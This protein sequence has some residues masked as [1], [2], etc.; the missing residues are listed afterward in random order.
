M[1]RFR[2]V[3]VV[4]LAAA[5]TLAACSSSSKTSSSATTAAGGGVTVTT[6]GSGQSVDVTVSDTQGTN[7]PMTLVPATTS[8][9][10]GDVTF[11][12]KNT[13]TIEHEMLVIKTDTPFDKIPIVDAGDPPVSVAT[14][15]NKIDEGG[16]VADTGSTNLKP[17]ETRNLD[18]KN[19]APG[20]YVLVCNIADHYKLGMRA[21][22]T[23]TA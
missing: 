15:A 1:S 23:V 4:V 2:A 10:A 14:G 3:S 21:A 19:L 9:K 16:S 6:A 18:A 20:N 22:F 8:A 11:V 12:I 17:G 5:T 7:G 13:G